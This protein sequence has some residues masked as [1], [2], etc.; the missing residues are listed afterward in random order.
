MMMVT[1]MMVAATA[2]VK[3]FF[4]LSP[5]LLQSVRK[6]S[7]IVLPVAVNGMQQIHPVIYLLLELNRN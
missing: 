6:H 7:A 1:M 5:R 2:T 3:I 4:K